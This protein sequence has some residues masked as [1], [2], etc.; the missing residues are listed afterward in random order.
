MSI[1]FDIDFFNK[2]DFSGSVINDFYNST[3]DVWFN[4]DFAVGDIPYFGFTFKNCTQKRGEFIKD[5]II[6]A[7]ITRFVISK[8]ELYDVSVSFDNGI[9]LDFSCMWIYRNLEMYKGKSYKNVYPD[10][11]KL[12][13]KIAYVESSEYFYD[14]EDIELP[15]GYSLNVKSYSDRDENVCKAVLDVCEL[16]KNGEHVFSY[17]CTYNHTIPCKGLIYHSNG[18]KYLPFQVDLYGISY[19]NLD[20]GEVYH[21]IPEGFPHDIDQYCGESFIITD[22]HYDPQSD[23]IAYGGCYWADLYNVM[24]GDFSEPLN[25]NPHLISVRE[26]IDPENDEGWEFDFV[27]FEDGKLIVKN[28][29]NREFSVDLAEIKAK[30]KALSE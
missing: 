17:R 20:S 18:H 11:E 19:L 3:N 12:L 24:V 1:D 13:E 30:I 10:W 26:I 8:S 22:I 28:D 5:R 6:G 2:L 9:S 14:E 21:Y 25:Y 27:R 23:L 15:E 4:G 7:K 16:T 29:D